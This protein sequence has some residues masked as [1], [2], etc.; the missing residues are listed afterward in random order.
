MA[1]AEQSFFNLVLSD[2][3]RGIIRDAVIWWQAETRRF[4]NEPLYE[5]APLGPVSDYFFAPALGTGTGGLSTPG[6]G[7]VSAN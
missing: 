3:R 5:A 1:E 7:C 6:G 4:P 2:G